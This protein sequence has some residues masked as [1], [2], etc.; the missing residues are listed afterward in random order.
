ME[1]KIIELGSADELVMGSMPG[2]CEL[3]AGALS[4]PR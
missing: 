3:V 2:G 1:N 4:H